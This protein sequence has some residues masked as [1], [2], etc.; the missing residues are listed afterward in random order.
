MDDVSSVVKLIQQ[1]DIG[2]A[3]N[4]IFGF[5]EDNYET[6]QQTLDLALELN[7]EMCNMYPCQALPG[8][9]LHLKAKQE[10][11]DLPDTYQGYGFLSYET[12]PLATN[13]VSAAE[14]V[15]FRD[16]AWHKYHTSVPFLELIERKFG[17]EAKTGIEDLS[18]V[19]LKRRIL[20]D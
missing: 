15:R 14:V 19:K 12:T 4:Y 6:M 3:A 13:Y 10:G 8:S 16:D 11:W 2:V 7:T 1:H 18:K 9:P 5:P 17:L 20:G